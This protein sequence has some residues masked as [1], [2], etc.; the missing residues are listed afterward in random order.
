MHCGCCSVS[1]TSLENLSLRQ[2][3]SVR[4]IADAGGLSAA[5]RMLNRSQSALSK[6]LADLERAMGLALFDRFS[7]GV[8]PTPQGEVLVARIREAEGQ[9]ELAD[10]AHRAFLRRAPRQLHNPVFSMEIS[11]KRLDAFLAV[12]ECR[13]VGRTAKQLGLTRSAIYDSLRVLEE[14]LELPLFEAGPAGMRS[15]ACADEL[16]MHVSLAFSLIQHGLDEIG[17]RDGELR[18]ALVVGTLPYSRTLLV[19]RAIDRLLRRHPGL[20][21]AT[22]EGP[23]D[24]LER[25][26]R[27]GSVDLIIGATRKHGKGSPLVAENLFEDELAVICGARHPLASHLRVRAGELLDYGWVLP[28]RST[29]ARQLFDEFLAR[30]GLDEPGQVIETGSLSMARGLLLESERLALLS[31]H[32][33]QLDLDAGLLSSLPIRLEETFRPI[34]I[35]SRANSTPSQA[36]REFMAILRELTR[37]PPL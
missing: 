36:A 9:F 29:P 33:V 3:R 34:G 15:T 2:L 26:L 37:K 32:Q 23:Y 25:A 18:G 28:V 8:T 19:P 31:R 30:H 16:A 35:T 22:R 17:S 6:S 24:V 5:A 14:L 21:I 4:V 27:S 11:R 13:D 10:R 7:H 20:R 12:H 1:Q